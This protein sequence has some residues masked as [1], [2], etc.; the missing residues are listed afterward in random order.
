VILWR[1]SNY[2][3]LSGTGGVLH[4]GRW[5]HRGRPIVYLAESPAA[6]L[7]EV[8][9]HV[10]VSHPGELP[11]HYQLMEIAL[12]DGV[13]SEDAALPET[14][15]WH[16]DAEATRHCGNEWLTQGRSLLLRVPSAVVGRSF[17]RLFNPLHPQAPQAVV[18]SVGRYPFDG[19]LFGMPPG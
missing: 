17:N 7:L 12:P 13:R 19:R 10:Q 9:V 11:A 14:P 16:A 15:D 4:P 5:H 8:L 3:D 1:I 6:A 18:C 2:A